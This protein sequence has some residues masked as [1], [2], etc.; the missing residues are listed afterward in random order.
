MSYTTEYV[1]MALSIIIAATGIMTAYNKYANFDVSKPEEETGL[2]GN[3]FYIDELYH[4]LF[5]QSTK[6]VSMFIDKVI[7]EKIIDGFIMSASNSFVD[8]GKKVAMIQN[9]NVR[10]YAAF[11]LIGMTCIFIYLII[12]LGL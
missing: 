10:Y 12:T 7:D 9:A 2:I 8:I 3:K 1:L 4:I 11:M 6:K 5:V